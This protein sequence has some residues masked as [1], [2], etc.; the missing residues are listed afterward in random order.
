M[1]VSGNDDDKIDPGETFNLTIELENTGL[2]EAMNITSILRCDH[3]SITILDSS[4]SFENIP[5]SAIGN[6]LA[7]QF[8]VEISPDAKP[9]IFPFSLNISEG[10]GFYQKTIRFNLAIGQ[11]RILLVED[12]GVFDLSHYYKN[13][14]EILGIPYLHWS[15]SD[16]GPVVQDTLMSYRRVIWYTG[17]EFGNSL[18][19]H[20]TTVLEN[21]LESGGNLFINGS[22][23]PFSVRDSLLMSDYLHAEYINFKTE[24]HHLKSDGSKPVLGDI[25]FWLSTSDDNSQSLTGEIDAQAPAQ[26]ILFYDTN[27]SEGSGNIQSSGAAAIAVTDKNYRVAMFSFGWEGIENGEI[28]QTVLVKILNWLQGTQTAIGNGFADGSIPSSF[29]LFQNYPNPFNPSTTIQF[30]VPKTSRVTIKIFS[31]LGTEIKTLIN[32]KFDAGSYKVIWDGKDNRNQ[33]VTSGVYFY[34]MN[35]G[36]FQVTR[37]MILLY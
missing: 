37:K 19:K 27:T 22:L 35:A 29:E 1:E 23:F 25:N 4:A 26:P 31:I 34:Q 13:I 7:D 36:D 30:Y 6:N 28:R 16:R 14:L 15:T 2:R 17:M 18:F 5:Q 12:D 20:G 3:P 8:A 32:A 24:L 11:G 21:Y 33:P 9:E 10:G